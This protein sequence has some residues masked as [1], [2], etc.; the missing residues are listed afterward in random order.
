MQVP[1]STLVF[2]K[3]DSIPRDGDADVT[4]LYWEK[5]K[6]LIKQEHEVMK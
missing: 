6:R 3:H 4:V 2:M 1:T 5:K